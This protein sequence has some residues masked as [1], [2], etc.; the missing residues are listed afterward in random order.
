MKTYLFGHPNWKNWVCKKGW[1]GDLKGELM[2][3]LIEELDK[4]IEQTMKTLDIFKLNESMEEN[5]QK[6]GMLIQNAE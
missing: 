4:R 1:F 2:N 3:E 6:L 5:M